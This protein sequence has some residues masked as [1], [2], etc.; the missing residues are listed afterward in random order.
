M[1]EKAAYAAAF[2]CRSRFQVTL[3][4]YPQD[5]SSRQEKKS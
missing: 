3:A 5:V 1:A 4:R 2:V